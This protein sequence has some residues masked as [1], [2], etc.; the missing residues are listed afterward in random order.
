MA[1][2]Y[3]HR[4]ASMAVEIGTLLG[5][6]APVLDRFRRLA[7][8]AREAWRAEFL[9]PDGS[10]AV[11]TQASHVRALALGMLD[12]GEA[13]TVSGRLVELIRDAG[14][15]L[16]TGFLSTGLLLPM[17]AEAGHGDVAYELLLQDTEPSWL[18]MLERGATTVWESWNG[19]DEHGL[20]HESL[21]QYCKGGVA[22]FLLR[23]TGGLLPTAPG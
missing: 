19:I 9:L 10:L 2:A 1:T 12:P 17:L 22:T 20:A 15:H 6:A 11:Q 23:Y 7:E 4:S 13:P 16:G 18:T 21:N 8:G 5:A 3:L 14:T